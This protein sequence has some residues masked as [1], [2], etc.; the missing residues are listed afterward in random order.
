MAPANSQLI[1]VYGLGTI[2]FLGSKALVPV[3][4]TLAKGKRQ[5]SDIGAGKT[6]T[7]PESRSEMRWLPP[8]VTVC[9]MTCGFVVVSRFF[10]HRVRP[11]ASTTFALSA[12]CYLATMMTNPGGIPDDDR[13]RS[14]CLASNGT[15]DFS[16]QS[17]EQP[18][19]GLQRALTD[20]ALGEG[21]HEFKKDGGRRTCKRCVKY[22]PDR[23]HHCRV[24]RKCVLKMDHHCPW[25]WNCVGFRNNRFFLQLLFYGQ[26]T[27]LSVWSAVPAGLRFT[28]DAVQP[29]HRRAAVVGV[30]FNSVLDS[31]MWSGFF[32]FSLWRE[33]KGWSTIEYCEKNFS[34]AKSCAR[35]QYEFVKQWGRT[36]FTWLLPILPPPA[37][38][39]TRFLLA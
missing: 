2:V 12:T 33:A 23:A 10:D 4:L 17:S 36:P 28:L 38:D 15:D 11:F 1:P 8:L 25:A 31:L 29:W 7:L 35:Y 9:Y 34:A 22:K 37:K 5:L 30:C 3:V 18:Q 24:C 26:L 13:W 16:R 32:A 6:N 27:Y 20:H 39:G 19:S 21:Q 14:E